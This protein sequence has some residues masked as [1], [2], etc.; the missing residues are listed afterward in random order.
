MFQ[1]FLFILCTYYE[2][3]LNTKPRKLLLIIFTK[4]KIMTTK[5]VGGL[6]I[7]S[8]QNYFVLVGNNFR[9]KFSS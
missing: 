8:F 9:V 3:Y 5:T 1:I 7:E 4:L 2:G 6:N